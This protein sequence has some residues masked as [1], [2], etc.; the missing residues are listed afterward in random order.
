MSLASRRN[1]IVAILAAL[2]AVFLLIT[3]LATQPTEQRHLTVLRT[4]A[5]PLTVVAGSEPVALALGSSQQFYARAPVV[6]VATAAAS[7]AAADAAAH[8]QVPALLAGPGLVTE[9]RRLKTEQVL[10]IGD[11]G[12]TRLGAIDA[13][14]AAQSPAS[15]DRGIVAIEDAAFQSRAVANPGNAFVVTRS[16]TADA[17]ALS[18]ARNAGAT[19]IELPGGDPR[20]VP[21]A[22]TL[23]ANR[24]DSPV[25]ALGSSFAR[26]FPYT[27]AAVRTPTTLPGGG[28]LIFP[29]RTMIALY[30]YPGS[31]ALGVLGEQGL[32]AS[33]ARA[34]RTAQAYQKLSKTP[35][36]PAF[37]I[38]A[39]VATSAA[40]KDKDY[41]SE[42]PLPLLRTWIEA[43][44]RAG[45]YVVLD[46]QPGR[47]DFLTQ[48]KRYESLLALPQVG[49]ALDPEWRLTR[50]QR[51]LR[52]IGSVDVSE[53]NRTSA[54][55]A[56]LTRKHALPQKLLVLHQF[57]DR[58][59][60]HRSKLNNSH[61]ELSILIHVDGQGSQPAKRGTWRAIR[62][63]APRGVFWGWKNFY[64][65]D[66]PTLSIKKTWRTV[67]PRPNFVSYQ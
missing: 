46:L 43:A 6:V 17:V 16:A 51:P 3:T 37:E 57:Q 18:T 48:A 31:S 67:K 38:I 26:D 30:G 61:P 25:V 56:A 42:A 10:V 52:Q 60:R 50:H 39:T 59:I 49:L 40:G 53:I 66:T 29:G 32:K 35:V 64:D 44:G 65:E 62:Q 20:A 28:H 13:V 24:P 9:L 33:I 22:A 21:A 14:H 12:Q 63:D 58:M 19:V 45:M 2:T 36:I 54:W 23:L 7:R 4:P 15:I 5:A 55:L 8:L 1:L 27:L 41:S 34:K 47:S 11:I